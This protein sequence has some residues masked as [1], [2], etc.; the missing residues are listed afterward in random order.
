MNREKRLGDD[1]APKASVQG[2]VALTVTSRR[3]PVGALARRLLLPAV[4]SLTLVGCTV[5]PGT[6]AWS[7]KQSLSPSRSSAHRREAGQKKSLL[8]SFF[9]PEEPEPLRTTDDWMA[10]E[11]IRP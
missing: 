9:R 8:A 4:L 6:G 10:L 7:R 2:P 5:M 3:A 11:Q 1:Q